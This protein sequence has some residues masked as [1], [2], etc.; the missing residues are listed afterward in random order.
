MFFKSYLFVFLLSAFFANAAVIAVRKQDETTTT[1]QLNKLRESGLL[2]KFDQS[3]L[4]GQLKGMSA[5][6]ALKK[7]VSSDWFKELKKAADKKAGRKS[8]AKQSVVNKAKSIGILDKLKEWK[9]GSYQDKINKMDAKFLLV[10]IAQ[11]KAFKDAFAKQKSDR[12]AQED[13]VN[14]DLKKGKRPTI[15]KIIQKSKGKPTATVIS[16]KGGPAITLAATGTRTT[17]GGKAYTVSP[18]AGATSKDNGAAGLYVMG[19]ALAKFVAV[20]GGAFG[21]MMLVL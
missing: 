10:K 1:L 6:D 3:N 2:A 19:S 5:S 15:V 14:A 20:I 11:S 4:D 7:V 8:N 18:T 13:K 12:K 21:G 16:I 17:F 9:G